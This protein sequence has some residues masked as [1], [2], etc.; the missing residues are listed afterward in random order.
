MK[1]SSVIKN[2]KDL[3]KKP[4]LKRENDE[5]LPLLGKKIEVRTVLNSSD[6]IN[7]ETIGSGEPYSPSPTIGP[8]F[9]DPSKTSFN[10]PKP[11]PI[12]SKDSLHLTVHSKHLP[13]PNDFSNSTLPSYTPQNLHSETTIPSV[14]V[15]KAI[16]SSHKASQPG[17]SSK[18][19]M[20]SSTQASESE[21]PS[22][23]SSEADTLLKHSSKKN[24][25]SE[26]SSKTNVT[27]KKSSTT[28]VTSRKSSNTDIISK[29]SSDTNIASKR[30]SLTDIEPV[31]TSE[32]NTPTGSVSPSP[33]QSSKSRRLQIKKSK[34]NILSTEI[35]LSKV[36]IKRSK[37]HISEI[38]VGDHASGS[39]G[40]SSS[41]QPRLFGV[42]EKLS[43]SPL[44][45]SLKSFIPFIKS[46]KSSPKTLKSNITQV[47]TSKT[48]V[49][50]KQVAELKE[51]SEDQSLNNI[52][53]VE[54]S[55]SLVQKA[56]TSET[57]IISKSESPSLKSSKAQSTSK[58][59]HPPLKRVKSNSPPSESQKS[60][61]KSAKTSKSQKSPRKPIFSFLN[62][63]KVPKPPSEPP[64][65]PNP[66]SDSHKHVIK[67]LKEI[68]GGEENIEEYKY[69]PET[70]EIREPA[71]YR[72]K[73]HEQQKDIKSDYAYYR[74]QFPS[75]SKIEYHYR[76]Q[77]NFDEKEKNYYRANMSENSTEYFYRPKEAT[78]DDS[79]STYRP[80]INESRKH[81]YRPNANLLKSKVSKENLN[82]FLEK[83]E[84]NKIMKKLK[85]LMRSS[86]FKH[87]TELKKNGGEIHKNNIKK[88][89]SEELS[90]SYSDG[91]QH[92][93]SKTE[94]EM[95]KTS[96]DESQLTQDEIDKKF[97]KVSFFNL[98]TRPHEDRANI[99][100]KNSLL[101]VHSN[102]KKEN[103]NKKESSQG[104]KRKSVSFSSS[105]N[106]MYIPK[107]KTSEPSIPSLTKIENTS[108][109]N[110]LFSKSNESRESIES[111]NESKKKI[112]FYNSML[113][114][115]KEHKVRHNSKNEP[116]HQVNTKAPLPQNNNSIYPNFNSDK[117]SL[118]NNSFSL[119]HDKILSQ[120]N[121]NLN[122]SLQKR[123]R[124]MIHGKNNKNSAV[125]NQN[126]EKKDETLNFVAYTNRMMME[127]RAHLNITSSCSSVLTGKDFEDDANLHNSNVINISMLNECHE[128]CINEQTRLQERKQCEV[129][130]K[131]NDGICMN[132]LEK[133]FKKA[134]NFLNLNLDEKVTI[135]AR[136]I[137]T[138]E[139]EV[140]L[141]DTNY[142]NHNEV[143]D[144]IEDIELLEKRKR[145]K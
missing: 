52:T 87:S 53:S 82:E 69:R 94:K 133:P 105:P 6:D 64:K 90:G 118:G 75:D 76:P 113:M 56:K 28:H 112:K 22:I 78:T 32:K 121:V 62:F 132:S 54:V 2:K 19:H 17:Y 88:S 30:L 91:D 45:S 141:K 59:Q 48:K 21:V 144:L 66:S 5:K 123:I 15:S 86:S 115:L 70:I 57:N 47:N 100:V 126:I 14:K 36:S 29:N 10:S 101:K 79:K 96:S 55:K 72:P 24:S 125:D 131:N 83:K 92:A 139:F 103:A 127:R 67:R 25:P 129:E 77:I 140:C 26:N 128:K 136:N 11:S 102:K 107:E 71:Y 31:K 111:N 60:T 13:K 51:L 110:N 35:P 3:N 143:D 120:F 1:K 89:H 8:L 7:A 23:Q 85:D 93:E 43:K 73:I 34:S 38:K 145:L 16:Y 37:S 41:P 9:L 106:I 81:S 39:N 116:Y 138:N 49:S 117:D 74:A 134:N 46:L 68:S 63:S 42:S 135:P 99:L 27:S 20:I 40:I 84:S 12:N 104:F 142:Q 114:K 137:F 18:Y 130:G 95:K 80:Q 109:M 122:N 50:P 98:F 44:L 124:E 97:A 119:S 65:F 61:E 108:Q 4:T 33:R 58:L